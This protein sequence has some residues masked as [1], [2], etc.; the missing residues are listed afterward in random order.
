MI[1]D[2]PQFVPQEVCLSCDG[3][4]KFKEQDSSWRP[5]VAQEETNTQDS[6]ANLLSQELD[7]NSSIKTIACQEQFHCT[8]FHTEDHKC[9]IYGYRP[10][11]C[12]LYPFLLTKRE[13]TP[14]ICVHLSCPH[15]QEKW[16]SE[17]FKSHVEELKKYFQKQE[18]L[19]FIRR[20]PSLIGDYSKYVEEIE[21]LF[22]LAL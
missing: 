21:Y 12:R 16:Q 4:C 1:K 10:F 9:H 18:I 15:I 6:T 3:C 22:T 20:N 2:L 7:E 19:A 17:D 5:K 8:F 14:A 13:E 11:E